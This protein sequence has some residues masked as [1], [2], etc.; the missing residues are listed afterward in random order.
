MDLAEA[1]VAVDAKSEKRAGYGWCRAI[2][3]RFYF[4]K[5]ENAGRGLTSA[6]ALCV[7]VLG[8]EF[9]MCALPSIGGPC[10]AHRLLLMGIS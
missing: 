7:F 2:N 5:T 6:S 4:I 9:L 10:A 8:M 1:V 3:A